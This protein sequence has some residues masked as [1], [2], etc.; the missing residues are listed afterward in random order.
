MTEHSTKIY[1]WPSSVLNNFVKRTPG[2]KAPKTG[3]LVTWLIWTT[4][5]RTSQRRGYKNIPLIQDDQAELTYT[6]IPGIFPCFWCW[7]YMCTATGIPISGSS[8]KN[9][10]NGI[11]NKHEYTN[12]ATSRENVSS[13]ILDQVTFK[14]AC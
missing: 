5:K 13:E 7:K 10:V 1:L 6:I 2:R 4:R 8:S 12:W 3:F 14:S 9:V 11:V